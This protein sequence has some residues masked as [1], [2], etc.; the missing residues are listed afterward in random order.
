MKTDSSS[1]ALGTPWNP[2]DCSLEICGQ[3]CQHLEFP[4][5][6]FFFYRAG[7]WLSHYSIWTQGCCG[8][9]RGYK[10]HLHTRPHAGHLNG[11]AGLMKLHHEPTWDCLSLSRVYHRLATL[12]SFTS[13]WIIC[14]VWTILSK[15]SFSSLKMRK[16]FI[17]PILQSSLWI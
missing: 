10:P 14:S 7:M 16:C 12:D 3:V 5:A 11:L 9:M 6:G 2:P 8:G 1:F 4:S 17:F 13:W 15:W